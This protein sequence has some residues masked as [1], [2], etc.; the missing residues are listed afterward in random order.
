MI[1]QVKERLKIATSE[2]DGSEQLFN[3]IRA[4]DKLIK[5][6]IPKLLTMVEDLKLIA[7]CRHDFE[8]VCQP[9]TSDSPTEWFS[10]CKHCGF[11]EG[12]FE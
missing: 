2:T 8:S 11:D 1:E 3:K 5:E 10:I 9:G 6:D 12:L 4:K 7:T